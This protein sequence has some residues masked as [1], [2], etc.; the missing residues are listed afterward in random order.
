[1]SRPSDPARTAR[2]PGSTDPLPGLT[3]VPVPD[4]LLTIAEVARH[5]GVCERQVRTYIA[6]GELQAVRLGRQ[7]HIRI[8]PADLDRFLQPVVTAAD[9]SLDHLISATI[10]P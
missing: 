2:T 6:R 5:L 1:M 10:K 9:D 8:R 3:A 4:P 7:G